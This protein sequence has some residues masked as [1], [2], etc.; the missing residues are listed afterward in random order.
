MFLVLKQ[1]RSMA[2]NISVSL[3]TY[4]TIRPRR[5]MNFFAFQYHITC[6]ILCF[7][8][9]QKQSLLQCLQCNFKVCRKQQCSITVICLFCKSG[10][11]VKGGIPQA[12]TVWLASVSSCAC[13]NALRHTHTWVGCRQEFTVQGDRA[14]GLLDDYQHRLCR[15]CVRHWE[16]SC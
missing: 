12:V 13:T 14:A 6:V 5:N 1:I 10:L 11:E 8:N 7:H 4:L 9:V 15:A 16:M 3:S 2:E